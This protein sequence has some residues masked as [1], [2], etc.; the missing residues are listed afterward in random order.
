[1]KN[2][3]NLKLWNKEKF[4]QELFDL[5]FSEFLKTFFILLCDLRLKT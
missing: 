3:H 2:M 5:K 4:F 1:M